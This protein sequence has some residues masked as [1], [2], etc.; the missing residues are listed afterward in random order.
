MRFVGLVCHPDLTETCVR[1]FSI[2]CNESG[3][4]VLEAGGVC[5]VL[6]LYAL[7]CKTH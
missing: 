5:L 1:V 3:G 2:R 6:E 4:F 7:V